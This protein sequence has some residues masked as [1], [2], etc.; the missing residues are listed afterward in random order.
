MVEPVSSRGDFSAVPANLTRVE[1]ASDRGGDIPDH[2]ID[3]LI[4]E[5]LA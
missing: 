1:L 4:V 2:R 3:A 5:H